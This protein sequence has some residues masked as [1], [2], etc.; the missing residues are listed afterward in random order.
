MDATED[1]LYLFAAIVDSP[2]GAS[3]RQIERRAQ[4]LRE[5]LTGRSKDDLRKRR[6][7]FYSYLSHLQKDGL[8]ERRQ[9]KW[10]ITSRGKEK[11]KALLK[12]LPGTKYQ[13]EIDTTL[14]IVIFDI[15]E[16]QRRKREWLRSRLVDLGFRMIQKSVWAGKVK[17]PE[18]FIKDL[19]ELDLFRYVEIFTIS[20]SGSLRQVG[21]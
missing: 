5:G 6:T 1:S 14:K 21:Y 7:N 2:Y 19:Q 18:E 10:S 13:K 17:L 11:Y 3:P 16:K 9:R 20:K 15:P 12:R 8:I 4:E